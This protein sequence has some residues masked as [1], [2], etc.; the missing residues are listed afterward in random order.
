MELYPIVSDPFHERRLDRVQEQPS[1]SPENKMQMYMLLSDLMLWLSLTEGSSKKR[2]A[3]RKAFLVSRW[4]QLSGDSLKGA[5]P[6][7][8][9]L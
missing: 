7:A 6:G 8:F 5:F 1:R 2:R 3:A 4:M 9:L